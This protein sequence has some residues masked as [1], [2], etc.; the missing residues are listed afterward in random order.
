MT[1]RYTIISDIDWLTPPPDVAALL[2]V[3]EGVEVLTHEE[4]IAASNP[5]TPEDETVHPV[6][7]TITWLAPNFTPDPAPLDGYGLDRLPQF[8]MNTYNI[9]YATMQPVISPFAVGAPDPGNTPLARAERFF[10]ADTYLLQVATIAKTLEPTTMFLVHEYTKEP[11][12]APT[13]TL[14]TDQSTTNIT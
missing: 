4:S 12:K 3:T 14:P 11:F 5:D 1:R 7:Y 13:I 9:D 6:S 2:G 8:L 10:G